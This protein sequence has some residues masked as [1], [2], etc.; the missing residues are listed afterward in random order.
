[1]NENTLKAYDIGTHHMDRK[2]VFH[3][4]EIQAKVFLANLEGWDDISDVTVE[5]IEKFD[6]YLIGNAPYHFDQS[7]KENQRAFYNENWLYG[8]EEDLCSCCEK[9]IYNSIPESWLVCPDCNFCESCALK[10]VDEC[11]DDKDQFRCECKLRIELKEKEDISR[12][13]ES[14]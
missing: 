11:E 1:M 5:R 8:S 12:S 9:G 13:H 3:Y 4:S 10:N 14:H 6:K 7:I 2:I